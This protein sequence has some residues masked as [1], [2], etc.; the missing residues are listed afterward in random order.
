MHNMQQKILEL[1]G[2]G[3]ASK[4]NIAICPQFYNI[5]KVPVSGIGWKMVI[6]FCSHQS[7]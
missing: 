6:A 3:N 5:W 7:H 2:V 1:F 4:A